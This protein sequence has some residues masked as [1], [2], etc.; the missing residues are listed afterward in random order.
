M[1]MAEQKPVCKSS[2]GNCQSRKIDSNF[3]KHYQEFRNYAQQKNK[4][5]RIFYGR[6]WV[7]CS[8]C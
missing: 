7:Y 6:K 4:R 1:E 2:H 3:I 5:K 8:I